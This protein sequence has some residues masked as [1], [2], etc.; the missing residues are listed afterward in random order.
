MYFLVNRLDLYLT[1]FFYK[2][3]GIDLEIQQEKQ[4]IEKIELH[5]KKIEELKR[6]KSRKEMLFSQVEM[7][8]D[9]QWR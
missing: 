3:K 1:L 6:L 8:E 9:R 4:E 7:E 5:L 2:P